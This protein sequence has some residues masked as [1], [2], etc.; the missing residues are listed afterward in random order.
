MQQS[1]MLIERLVLS[2]LFTVVTIGAVGIHVVT[3]VTLRNEAGYV[4]DGHSS[5][6]TVNC[7]STGHW[8]PSNFVNVSANVSILKNEM[9]IC[10]VSFDYDEVIT[11]LLIVNI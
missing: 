11:K 3:V 7:T 4:I 1:A 9:N 6:L 8:S 5:S 2:L 10:A